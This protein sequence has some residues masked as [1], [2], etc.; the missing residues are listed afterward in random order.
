LRDNP[1]ERHFG[2]FRQDGS[3]KPA[4][5]AWEKF[6]AQADDGSGQPGNQPSPNWLKDY[7]SEKFYERPQEN[8]AELFK[9]YKE[10]D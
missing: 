1:H 2:L 8:L 5:Q 10:S 7:Q 3:A 9:R 4:V 6:V